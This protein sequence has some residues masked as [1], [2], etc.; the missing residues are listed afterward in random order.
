M[1]QELLDLTDTRQKNFELVRSGA[2]CVRKAIADY[3]CDKKQNH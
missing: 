1:I 3:I 2:L